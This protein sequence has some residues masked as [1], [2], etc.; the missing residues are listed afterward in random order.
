M[1]YIKFSNMPSLTTWVK[2]DLKTFFKILLLAY[3]VKPHKLEI[4]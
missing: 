1:C 4:L 2:E 3:E